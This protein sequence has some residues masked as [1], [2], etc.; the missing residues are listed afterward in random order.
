MNDS[1]ARSRELDSMRPAF[2]WAV[3]PTLIVF[4][5]MPSVGNTQAPVAPVVTDITSSG[6][7][8]V[9][10][11][12]N[13]PPPPDGVY[14][15][16]GGARPGDGPNLFHSFGNF[17]IGQGHIANFLN[18]SGFATTN[19]IG[20]VT[21]GNLSNIYGTIQTTDPTT[22]FGN[23]NLFLV[24]LSGFVFGPQGS[25]DVGGSVSFSTAQYLRLF[26]S[27]N[28]VSANFYADPANDDLPNSVFAMA[29]LDAFG[30][31]PA[32]YGFLTAPD[33]GATITVQG[34]DLSVDPGQS[35][36]LVGR[37]VVIQD[38]TLPD[39]TIQRAH[40]SAPDG[41]IL[42]AS[43][44]SPGEF[45]VATLQALPNV[46]GVSGVSFTSFGSVSLTAGS[47]INV[48]GANTVFV[49]GGQLV[50]SVNNATLTTT[51]DSSADSDTIS[52]AD[53]ESTSTRCSPS[54]V[55]SLVT[56]PWRSLSCG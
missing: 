21:G 39:E 28:G 29:P 46:D 51:S 36:S 16:T 14:N 15:I 25:F 56:R 48:T 32:A 49:K 31:L 35:I 40:L 7:G 44:A 22:G 53:A 8:T 3:L 37:E 27:L 41:S 38:A 45:D 55:N 30:F 10:P 4:L 6:L 24:N 52:P 13:L 19:I 18:D 1:T 2:L 5:V 34:S 12:P 43:A 50:L 26:D 54:N 9:V 23:A 17:S 33:P 42:L 11:D 47:S 20:R